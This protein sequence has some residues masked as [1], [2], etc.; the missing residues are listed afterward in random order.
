MTPLT[1]TVSRPFGQ[2]SLLS[3]SAHAAL[4]STASRVART[5]APARRP[6]ETLHKVIS[7]SPFCGDR[8]RRVRGH[9]RRGKSWGQMVDAH[10]YDRCGRSAVRVSME[11]RHLRYFVALAE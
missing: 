3:L 9:D 1:N 6:A 11:L 2:R 8:K 4:A 5:R 10:R 7:L